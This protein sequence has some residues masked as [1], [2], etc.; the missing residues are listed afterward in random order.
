ME[1]TTMD[2]KMTEGALEQA[3][4]LRKDQVAWQDLHLRLFIEGKGC[5]GFYYGVSF[6]DVRPEDMRMSLGDFDLLVDPDTYEFV[7]GSLIT[8]VDDERGRGFLV[9]NPNH[10][11]FKGKF[12]RR[13]AWQ[14]K[15]KS[16]QTQA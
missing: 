4:C 11:K 14:E 3:I 13:P 16:K 9:E 1:A 5:D 12:Y 8:W 15:L 10:K 6:D 7:Q 2:I